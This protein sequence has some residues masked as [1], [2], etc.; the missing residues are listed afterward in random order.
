MLLD[1]SGLLCLHHQ[2]EPSHEHIHFHDFS[3]AKGHKVNNWRISRP[4]FPVNEGVRA[5]PLANLSSMS[6]VHKRFIATEIE[7]AEP[8][9]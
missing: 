6:A 2:P 9:R 5:R 1:T 7:I 4:E 8:S 3:L